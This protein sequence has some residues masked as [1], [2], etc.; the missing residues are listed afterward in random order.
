MV[1]MACVL[2]LLRA[3]GRDFDEAGNVVAVLFLRR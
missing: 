1:S 2:Y 3:I